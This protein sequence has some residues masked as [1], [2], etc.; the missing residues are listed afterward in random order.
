MASSFVC[1]NMVRW[2][3]FGYIRVYIFQ[4]KDLFFVYNI[5]VYM[6]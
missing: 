4:L 6:C 3:V 2:V 5:M 1:Y